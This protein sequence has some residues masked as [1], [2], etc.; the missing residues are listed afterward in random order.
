MLNRNRYQKGF[1]VGRML[2]IKYT[3]TA[4]CKYR[5]LLR[6]QTVA[7]KQQ[8]QVQWVWKQRKSVLRKDSRAYESLQEAKHKRE[9]GVSTP[10]SKDECGHEAKETKSIRRQRIRRIFMRKESQV[11]HSLKF[12]RS[13]I[14][15]HNQS[16]AKIAEENKHRLL[17]CT[18]TQL[19][20]FTR[21]C[22]EREREDN[23]I[24]V[25]KLRGNA[26]PWQT[27]D[28]DTRT[29]PTLHGNLLSQSMSAKRRHLHTQHF[30]LRFARALTFV[31]LE[32]F[33]CLVPSS[34]LLFVR[35]GS[36]WSER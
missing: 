21:A 1:S 22:R 35:V 6:D 25:K 7:V 19:T 16:K 30:C 12:G 24:N 5:Y 23:F 15:K 10:T 33:L 8:K 9:N 34:S 11:A 17:R 14:K 13:L 4:N 27:C 3:N 26:Q 2:P 31:P 18:K 36:G 32:A 28:F 20:T 29:S